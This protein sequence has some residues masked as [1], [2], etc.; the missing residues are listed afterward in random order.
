[1]NRTLSL[2]AL[3][4]LATFG[5]TFGACKKTTDDSGITTDGGGTDGGGT[6][7]GTDGGG[8]DGGGTDGGGTAT[9]DFT[10]S[11]STVDLMSHSAV[12][13]GTC[14]DAVNPDPAVT[15]GD[16]IIMASAKIG[17]DGSFSIAGVDAKPAFGILLSI[18]DCTGGTAVLTT[19][20][21][22][23]PT[24]YTAVDVGGEVSGLKIGRAHV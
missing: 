14:I 21:P 8:T 12:A 3:A 9:I 18:K 24:L 16:P 11:G 5:L 13:A 22:V 19:A 1:M 6:D 23:L 17:S 20:T 10:L 7:G 2:A 4:T 15:G